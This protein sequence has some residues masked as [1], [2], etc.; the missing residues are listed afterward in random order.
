MALLINATVADK[1]ANSYCDTSYGDDYWENNYNTT[2]SAVW[3]ALSDDQKESA[4]ID[5]CRIIE[6]LR[7]T[8]KSLVQPVAEMTYSRHTGVVLRSPS[9]EAPTRFYY[10]QALQFPRNL[11][12]DHDTGDLYIREEVKSAQCEQAVYLVT[13]D[14]S[15][16]ANR[17]QG[18]SSDRVTVGPIRVGQVFSGNPSM[19]APMALEKIRPLLLSTSHSMRRA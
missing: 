17:M 16:M 6:T 1:D 10:W 11:D 2:K 9:T 19:I 18:V 4:L 8:T 15:V 14:E 7:F 13:F 3:A 12:T 5:A